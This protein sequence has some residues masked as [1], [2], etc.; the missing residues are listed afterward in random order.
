[1]ENLPD[2]VIAVP[3]FGSFKIVINQSREGRN[4]HTGTKMS[5]PAK[6]ALKFRPS[7][8]IRIAL[9]E[10]KIV[11]QKAKPRSKKEAKAKKKK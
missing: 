11:E 10:K 4:P 8:A 3:G 5:I 7:A 9:G 2:F 1:M 6:Y